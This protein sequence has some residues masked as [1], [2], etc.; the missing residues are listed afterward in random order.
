MA[1]LLPTNSLPDDE[2]DGQL[3]GSSTSLIEELNALGESIVELQSNL[4]INTETSATV[5]ELAAVDT[6]LQDEIANAGD[7]ANAALASE[8]GK[9]NALV[10]GSVADLTARTDD[11]AT[12]L[13]VDL[14]EEIA[15]VDV[16][17]AAAL[18][19]EVGTLDSAVVA[20][21][22]AARAHTDDVAVAVV[23]DLRDEIASSGVDSAAALASEVATLDDRIG[24]RQPVVETADA[25][26]TLISSITPSPFKSTR[27]SAKVIAQRIDKLE[28]ASYLFEALLRALPSFGTL[29]VG[30]TPV[31]GDLI[32]VDGR[33]YTW[34]AVITPGT[35]FQVASGGSAA[36]AIVN[37]V[38]AI[39]LS[40]VDD[41]D[42]G[43]GTTRHPTV[44]ASV[45]S[46]STM[47]AVARTPGVAGDAITTTDT[48]AGV[49]L[50]WGGA[51]LASGSDMS[52]L[53][54]VKT[55]EH[56]DDGAWDAAMAANVKDVEFTGTGAADTEI[57]WLTE[58]SVVSFF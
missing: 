49:L 7:A 46:V 47:E 24:A 25:T 35:P 8:V 26:P 3:G 56:E 17:T 19:S 27:I 52:V 15:Q 37:M 20:N 50:S 1:P 38:K 29:T 51:T 16:D 36:Q 13:A 39:N 44:S 41:T 34:M 5:G 31:D 12:A 42:Y 9:L 57:E 18:A 23:V 54:A 2:L 48:E 28:A 21:A 45:A 11:V 58:V 6:R 10:A 40:G 22:A 43:A 4:G 55:V 33:D 32:T 14:R 53:G 30:G